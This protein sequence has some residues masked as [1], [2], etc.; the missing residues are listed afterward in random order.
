MR[1]VENNMK[2]ITCPDC[3]SVLEITRSDVRGNGNSREERLCGGG[4]GI[5]PITVSCAVCGHK[6]SLGYSEQEIFQGQ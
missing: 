2:R 5:C 6:I 1:I 4:A 3:D